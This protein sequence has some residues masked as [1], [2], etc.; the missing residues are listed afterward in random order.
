MSLA[1][2]DFAKYTFAI[3]FT[4]SLSNKIDVLSSFGRSCIKSFSLASGMICLVSSFFLYINM[5]D[6]VAERATCLALSFFFSSLT[7]ATDSL[8]LL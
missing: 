6:V 5:Y 3:A 8:S 7:G 2:F 4:I 1:T